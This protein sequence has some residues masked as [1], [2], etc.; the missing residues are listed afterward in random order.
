MKTQNVQSARLLVLLA[1]G[2]LALSPMAEAVSPPPDGG[3]PGGNTAESYSALLS[4]T[5]GV[6]NT[7]NGIYSLLSLTDGNFCTGVGAGTLLANTA[8]EN[9]ATGAGA[10]L[11]NLAGTGNTADGAFS[12]F[13]NVGGPSDPQQ[14]H[15]SF[16]WEV[17]HCHWQSCAV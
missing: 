6:Y 10:L 16:L 4:L 7:A 14:S 12:L 13:N 11:S 9:T 3:Y 15:W 1:L 2:W 5:T 17:Q 8:D